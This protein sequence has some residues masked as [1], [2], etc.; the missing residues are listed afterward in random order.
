VAVLVPDQ[1]FYKIAKSDWS[2]GPPNDPP[3]KFRNRV[4]HEHGKELYVG[5]LVKVMLCKR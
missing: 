2:T 1:D 5:E 4:C 3:Q